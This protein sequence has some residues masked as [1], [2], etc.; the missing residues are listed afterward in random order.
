MGEDVHT[1]LL[2]LVIVITQGHQNVS[3]KGEQLN[4]KEII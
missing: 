4:R 3:L 2:Y 1:H